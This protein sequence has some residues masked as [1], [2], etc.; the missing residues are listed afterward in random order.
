MAVG[1]GGVEGVGV[2]GLVTE[3]KIKCIKFFAACE[4]K[5][6]Q[7]KTP[8][9]R[10]TFLISHRFSE[11]RFVLLL[12]LLL[13]V[14]WCAVG[15]HWMSSWKKRMREKSLTEF[16]PPWKTNGGLLQFVQ[17]LL[18]E[19]WPLAATQV[20]N[21]CRFKVPLSCR[22]NF[23]PGLHRLSVC[24]FRP[25]PPPLYYRVRET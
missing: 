2:G 23:K 4:I 6:Y 25:L 12:F 1:G 7:K 9:H 20:L 3:K 16:Y 22:D 8:H 24:H 18:D 21:K 17:V 11:I 19:N 14:L 13:F 15:H 5:T 10:I